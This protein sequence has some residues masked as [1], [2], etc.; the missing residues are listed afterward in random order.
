LTPE[1]TGAVEQGKE[2]AMAKAIGIDLGTTNSCVAVMEGREAKVIENAEGMRTTP[3]MVAFT[4]QGE[5]LVGQPAKR[6]AIT[7]PENTLFAIKRL[8]GRRYDDPTTQKDKGMVPYRIV[9]DDDGDAWVEVKGKKYS[10][11]QISAYIL[12]KMKETAE[13]YSARRSGRR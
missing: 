12:Q 11:S 5:V 9:P 10:P 6:Q 4:D 2:A 1:Q 8:I 7:N 13:T 3:S